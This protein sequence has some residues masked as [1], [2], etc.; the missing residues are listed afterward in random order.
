MPYLSDVQ[1]YVE[2]LKRALKVRLVILY[3]STA[4]GS[5]GLGS[6]VDVLVVA[7][8]LPSNPVE[9]LKL[10][11]DLDKTRAPLDVKGYTPGE[12]RRML[13][14]GHPLIMDALSDGVVL[15]GEKAYVE[16]VKRAF[17]RAKRKFKRFERGWI[18]VG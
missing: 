17:N 1:E 11:Y 5:F 14:K 15:Y 13:A 18:K 2:S 9:R 7:D 3:G 8:D 10:L 6:D 16:E 4:K 12:V